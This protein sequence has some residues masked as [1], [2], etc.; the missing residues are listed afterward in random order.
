MACLIKRRV[1]FFTGEKM[2]ITYLLLLWLFLVSTAIAQEDLAAPVDDKPRIIG[3]PDLALKVTAQSA[4]DLTNVDPAAAAN[5]FYVWIR[6]P[7]DKEFDAIYDFV[8][9]TAVSHAAVLLKADR[10]RSEPAGI[11]LRLDLRQWI[12]DEKLRANFRKIINEEY[13]DPAFY[14]K[15]KET[16]GAAAE[17]AFTPTNFDYIQKLFGEQHPNLIF[18]NVITDS[19]END[20]N[21]IKVATEPYVKNGTLYQAAY[22]VNEVVDSPV[23]NGVIF[24]PA[25]QD[26]CSQDIQDLTTISGMT[27][28]IVEAERFMVFA[29][30]TLEG[31]LYYKLQGLIDAEGKRL[32]QEEWLKTFGAE[33]NVSDDLGGREFVGMWHSGVTSKPR[34]ISFFYGRNLRPSSGLPL[35]VVTQD[36]LDETDDTAVHPMYS[37]LDVK[38]DA[39]EILATK[40]NGM[41]AYGLFDG[42]GVLQD[43]APDNLVRDHTVPSPFTSR[44]ECAI[45]C[46]RCHGPHDQWIPVKNHVKTLLSNL[47][48][49][50]QKLTV[51]GDL[52]EDLDIAELQVRLAHL[53][54]GDIDSA[55]QL[56]R[57][58]F[59][60]ACAKMSPLVRQEADY[61][62][63]TVQVLS[64]RF[65]KYRYTWID[66]QEAL[67]TLGVVVSQ[68]QAN[69]LFAQVVPGVAKNN[70][71]ALFDI[72]LFTLRSHATDR[73][74]VISREDWERIYQATLAYAIQNGSFPLPEEVKPNAEAN[75]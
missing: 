30:R 52:T 59:E 55:L 63:W 34:K 39:A 71:P 3:R 54:N 45:S 68:D 23:T 42:N 13:F 37:L 5:S 1:C 6:D 49:Q 4:R 33:E 27:I 69:D 32:S 38:F 25:L 36:N 20:F 28:P 24:G 58:Q 7:Q 67:R 65:E 43:Q 8:L 19:T 29:L 44:L 31:G 51:V 57:D 26:L 47:D 64:E 21:R 46:I 60:K 18:K 16:I 62:K 17:V 40:P 15:G 35:V 70:G 72:A 12:P 9:N 10:I 56:A 75:Q 61:A 22:V 2:K 66:P 48:K 50:G 53:Y 73:E 11:I 74:L 14:V 41:I